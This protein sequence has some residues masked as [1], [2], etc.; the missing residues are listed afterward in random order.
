MTYRPRQT[1]LLEQPT[2]WWHHWHIS[3]QK[4]A[5]VLCALAAVTGFGYVMLTNS[6]AAQGFAIKGLEKQIAELKGQN[7]KL[8]LQADSVR[9]L[10]TVQAGSV[11]FNLQPTDRFD[12]LA[13][14]TDRVAVK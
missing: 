1:S 12:V 13:S 2:H 9:T 10:A 14:G 7:E 8:E 5:V 11:Q 6:T 4:L 3:T